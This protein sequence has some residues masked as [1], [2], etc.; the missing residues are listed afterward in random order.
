MIDPVRLAIASLTS[1]ADVGWRHQARAFDPRSGE[2]AR[3][4]GGRFNP[5]GSFP[6]LYLC[7]T[8][9]CAV[10][11]LR[12]LAERQGIGVANL[13]PRDLWR[14]EL[15]IERCLDLTVGE[16]L[17]VTGIEAAALTEPS[18][19]RTQQL[20][21]AAHDLGVQAIRSPSATGVDTVVAV[22]TENLGSSSVNPQLAEQWTSVDAFDVGPD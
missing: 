7:A 15:R 4:S 5:P 16:V 2:G 14:Y 20:G 18:W 19:S 9:P 3:L 8:R 10:A 17:E 21:A 22:F 11:E 13:L 12:R 6:V 1:L